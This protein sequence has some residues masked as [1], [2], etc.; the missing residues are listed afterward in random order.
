MWVVRTEINQEKV[1]LLDGVKFIFKD[2]WVL[3]LPDAEM[4]LCRVYSEGDSK[5]IAE[6]ISE[7]YLDRIKQII[8]GWRL[9]RIN[10]IDNNRR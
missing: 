5:E 1:E 9:R 2:S 7:K 4:P 8:T 6:A 10:E 3:I